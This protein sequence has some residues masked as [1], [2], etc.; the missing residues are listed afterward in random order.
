VSSDYETIYAEHAEE[1]DRLVG[2]EDCDANLLPAIARIAPLDGRDVLEVGAGTGRLTRL[3]VKAGARVR[4][5]DRSAAMLAVARRH[6]G[7][8]CSLEVADAE[9]L[10]T[11]DGWADLAIAGWVFGHFRSWMAADWQTHVARALGEMRR[12]L[13]PG[14]PL[15]VIETLGTGSETPAPPTAALAEYYAWLEAR[16][17]TRASI[18][19]DY[20]FANVE[21]AASVTGFF[22]GETFGQRV[23]SNGSARVPECTG[24]WSTTQLTGA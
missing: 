10:P 2:A 5:F 14:A 21:E 13:E 20:Q 17:F 23:R 12:A 4:A 15:V 22:F 9:H 11:S 6:L 24:I 18:R 8:S 3:L 19:T 7:D 1:Y 16:G